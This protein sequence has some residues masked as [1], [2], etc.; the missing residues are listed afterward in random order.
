MWGKGNLCTL[1]V[2]LQISIAIMENRMEAPQK[3][4]IELSHDTSTLP[5]GLYAR[6]LNWYV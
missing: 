5:W 1:L 3:L 4:K 2:K 6:K